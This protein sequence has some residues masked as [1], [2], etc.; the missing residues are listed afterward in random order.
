MSLR[1]APRP[2]PGESLLQA[3][4]PS[5]GESSG[6][7]SDESSGRAPHQA[8]RPSPGESFNESR[9]EPPGE[10]PREAPSGEVDLFALP[11][12][13]AAPAAPDDPAFRVADGARRPRP[14]RR[15][16]AGNLFELDGPLWRAGFVRVAGVDEAGRGPLAG[17]VVAAAV[18]FPPRVRLRGLDDS[19]KLDAAA[20][21]R[22][23]DVIHARALGVGVG[24]ASAAEIDALDILRATHL[25]AGRALAALAD[26]GIAPDAVVADHL[27]L[28]VDVPLVSEPRADG[29]SHAVA[30]ASVVAKVT[31]DRLMAR[32]AV[33]F[34]DYGLE[35]HKG[36]PTAAHLAAIARHGASTLHRRT[37]A[38]V[39]FFGAPARRSAT[40]ARL[41]AAWS[42]RPPVAPSARADASRQIDALADLLP[43]EELAALRALLA[44][45]TPTDAGAANR[46]A[47]EDGGR[48]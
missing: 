22:L 3:L 33:E 48:A 24:R 40:F 35:R 47:S 44:A 20:R 29:R 36:Y 43:E 2:S 39:E 10:A 16:G 8:P 17:P 41:R 4:R 6:E 42:A 7:S 11:T 31:R 28:A 30:A 26:A 13:W 21:E 34:P 5:S 38:G 46:F 14:L 19:K 37:F 23:F 12:V 32:L 45:A 25:A 18:V 1:K 15:R 27:R 9:C